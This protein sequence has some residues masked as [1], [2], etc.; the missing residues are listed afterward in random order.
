[1][2]YKSAQIRGFKCQVYCNQIARLRRAMIVVFIF[3][4]VSCSPKKTDFKPTPYSDL[5]SVSSDF[6]YTYSLDGRQLSAVKKKEYKRIIVLASPLSI[7]FTTLKEERNVVGV[8]NKSRVYSGMKN[9]ES[10]GENGKIDVE[11]IISLQPD[12]IICNTYQAE[13]IA[14]V[15]VNKV[16]IDEYLELSPRKRKTFSYLIGSLL[17]KE[18]EGR[19]FAMHTVSEKYAYK[20]L[21]LSVCKLDNFG[22]TWFEPG[23]NTYISQ[24]LIGAGA[25]FRCIKDSEK[26]EKVSGEK[27]TV[28]LGKSDYLLFLDWAKE[29]K[30][31][32]DRL[33]LLLKFRDHPKEIIYC[34]T[35]ESAYF[36]KSLVASVDLMSDLNT[37][38]QTKR[39]GKFFEI[40]DLEK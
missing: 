29:K 9:S 5:F 34:N 35:S 11:K 23:C 8:L 4:L 31:F 16:L 2:D 38:L 13:E 3:S 24:L 19:T 36:E 15:K 37:V 28:E 27:V 12:L 21:G 10:V 33:S 22:G 20:K 18:E 17:G 7:F 39:K 1:M 25:D 32:R 14:G 26:S 30:G 40:L 6:V